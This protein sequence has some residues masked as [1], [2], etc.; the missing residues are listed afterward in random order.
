MYQRILVAID[1][2]DTSR[3]AF[4]AALDLA[5]GGARL[6]PLFVIDD[7][8]LYFSVPGYDPSLVT[9]ARTEEGQEV[10]DQAADA[11]R[12]HSV[13]G[14]ALMV[15]A[16]STEGVAER[17]IRAAREFNAD[18]LVLG[19]HGRRGVRRLVL[20]S[21]AEQTVRLAGLPVLLVPAPGTEPRSTDAPA[22]DVPTTSR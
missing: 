8:P 7:L 22:T 5:R 12:S 20:G 13:D 21:V 18:L 10:M 1:G 2:S 15:T 11:M 14:E 3:N 16:D 4:F 17:I 6:R 9:R 19:T